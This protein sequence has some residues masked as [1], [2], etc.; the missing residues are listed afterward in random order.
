MNENQRNKD[1]KTHKLINMDGLKVFM[2]INK[3]TSPRRERLFKEL[4]KIA[5]EIMEV[6]IGV[7]YWNTD[8]E[9]EELSYNL[10]IIRTK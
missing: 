4:A 3:R 10:V 5:E 6:P 8:K 1:P 2:P 7:I 9:H